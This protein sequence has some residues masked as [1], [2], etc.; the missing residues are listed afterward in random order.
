VALPSAV[1]TPISRVQRNTEWFW[2]PNIPIP[3]RIKPSSDV[4]IRREVRADARLRGGRAGQFWRHES[5]DR[6]VREDEF[7]RVAR[8]ILMNPVRA[9][10]AGVPGEFRWCSGF[11][12]RVWS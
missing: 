4:R 5:Y 12:R 11:E 3:G 1:R 2:M 7:A 6:L 10:L 9:G 8:Y